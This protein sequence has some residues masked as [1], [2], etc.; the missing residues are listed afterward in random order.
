MLMKKILILVLPYVAF[1]LLIRFIL[2]LA[3]LW[4]LAGCRE[5]EVPDPGHHPDSIEPGSWVTYSPYKWSHDG[6][7]VNFDY[8]TVYSDGASDALKE[9]AGYLADDKFLEILDQFEFN[10]LDNFLYPTGNRKIE[11]YINTGHE[12][13]IAAAYWGSIFITVRTQGL[14]TGRYAYLFKHELAH[15]FEFLI[16]GT[17]NLA[18]DMWFTEGI[19]VCSGGG[20]NRINTVNDLELWIESNSSAPNKGNPITIRRWEDYPEGADKTGYYTIFE[21]VM[22]YMLD[23]EGLD[24]SW[25]DVLNV[26]YDLRELKAFEDSFR[27]NFGIEVDTLENGI[28]DRLSD[29]LK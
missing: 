4:L 26:F 21:V 18:A 2:A 11:V 25:Q 27:E 10:D 17:V 16:E 6:R 15:A 14:D 19:A 20:L 24:R 7:P 22:E 29:Y 1:H 28:F 12:E 13:N 3:I 9:S 23:Q 5:Q 8:C